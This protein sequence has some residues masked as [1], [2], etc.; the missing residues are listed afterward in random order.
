VPNQQIITVNV[1]S[2]L[3]TKRGTSVSNP[4]YMLS[5]KKVKKM[6]ALQSFTK[7]G[8]IKMPKQ[9]REP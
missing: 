8:A 3:G 6:L 4:Y 2:M 7:I 9:E 5:N 1:L